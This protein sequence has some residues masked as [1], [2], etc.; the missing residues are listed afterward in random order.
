MTDEATETTL[1]RCPACAESALAPWR[2]ATPASAV[3]G[4]P[5][6]YL[7][8]R[9]RRCG[10]AAL[11]EEPS[12]DRGS[13]YESGTYAPARS[14]LDRL[15]KG[16]RRWMDRDRLRLLGGVE[17]G[18][19]VLEVGAGRGRLAAAIARQ[20]A[21]VL[22]I[23][24]A[25]TS[26]AAARELG[27]SVENVSIEDAE[28]EP[29]SRDL[30]VIW[31]VL[32][33]LDSPAEALARV[34]Q[35]IA[36]GGRAVISVPNLGSLQAR[37]GGDRWFHQDVP[38]HRT[39]FTRDGLERRLRL[40]GFTPVR[41]RQAL[42]DQGLL[43]MWLT[44]LNRVTVA[45]DVPFRYLKRDLHYPSRARA[46]RD[47]LVTVVLGPPLLLVAVAL[48]LGAVLAGRGGSIVVEAR[49]D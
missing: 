16:P 42:I 37:I 33:H 31:H 21:D 19:R 44:L 4:A 43:G 10:S 3:A 48:E 34:R 25:T 27:V 17:P 47:A 40:S 12:G 2:T 49:P 46:A 29:G 14:P 18:E 32:E 24:P 30:I 9:C 26:S 1:H 23:E 7:L 38:R 20:G 15:L 22:G 35:W 5:G 8:L 39:Q 13:L 45:R 36:D 28:V 41:T 11:A 6:E